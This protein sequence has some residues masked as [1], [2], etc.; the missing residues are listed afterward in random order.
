[1]VV[2]RYGT[3]VHVAQAMVHS[4]SRPL[5]T[6]TLTVSSLSP[7]G[8]PGKKVSAATSRYSTRRHSGPATRCVHSIHCAT[9]A[10]TL[11]DYTP[12]K[13]PQT[14]IERWLREWRDFNGGI[15]RNSWYPVAS[16][17]SVDR[18]W[19]ESLRCI[20][21]SRWNFISL[22]IESYKWTLTFINNLPILNYNKKTLIEL[23]RFTSRP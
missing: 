23:K 14:Q 10:Q 6:L 11:A 3:V 19:R 7:P 2:L 1:M 21:L 8:L 13:Y 17:R 4:S 20:T 15:Y 18:N 5:H 16:R 12:S 9:V 22:N